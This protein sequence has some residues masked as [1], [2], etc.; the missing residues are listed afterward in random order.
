MALH[1]AELLQLAHENECD[2]FYEASVAGGIPIIR[3][4]VDGLASD[5]ITKMMGI[6][7]GTTNYILTKMDKQQRNYEEVLKEAQDLGY[8]EADPTS[9][10]EG[11][12]AARKMAILST[13]GFSMH[14]HLDDV[15]VS[16][17]SK[18]TQEDLEYARQFGYTLKLIGNAKRT[19]EKWR[20]VLNRHCFQTPTRLRAFITNTT[21]CMCM[22]NLLERR[23]S[24]V[25]VQGSSR[26]LHQL[27][28]I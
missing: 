27:F 16:G 10:V 23:C 7:N 1:G 19:T 12:D 8:A 22:V 21:P 6:V 9:D 3:S 5:R 4:L 18:V 17:I 11:I 24:S 20:S 28:P 26:L 14:I 13:L 2:L 25:Q 15:K